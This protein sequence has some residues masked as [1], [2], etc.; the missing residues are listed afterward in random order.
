M[1]EAQQEEGWL[2]FSGLV[3]RQPANAGAENASLKAAAAAGPV[4]GKATRHVRRTTRKVTFEQSE[5]VGVE[6]EPDEEAA[7]MDVELG[8]ACPYCGGVRR[9]LTKKCRV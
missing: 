5:P 2:Y 3:R 9:H 8:W 1:G 7:E 4:A 6:V